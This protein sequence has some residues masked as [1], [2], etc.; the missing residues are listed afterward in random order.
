MD[1]Y[2]IPPALECD[3]HHGSPNRLMCSDVCG[4]DHEIM[5]P[6]PGECT[7]CHGASNL[8]DAPAAME[9]SN[10]I[11]ISSIS[12]LSPWHDH[13]E[14]TLLHD[15][16]ALANSVY[17]FFCKNFSKFEIRWCRAKA[18]RMFQIQ[19]KQC[20]KGAYGTYPHWQ[21]H[22]EVFPLI[23]VLAAFVKHPLVEGAT[24]V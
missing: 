11:S 14:S 3:G 4:R 21:S 13:L 18:N 1:V 24:Q 17:A 22:A 10:A 23:Q 15:Q 8:L 16:S 7:C 5:K 12:Q 20:H 19:C 6:V 2:W 9:I